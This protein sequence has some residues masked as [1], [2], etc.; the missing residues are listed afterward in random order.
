[1]KA[2]GH[3]GENSLSWRI[4]LPGLAPNSHLSP[5]A[6]L[7]HRYHRHR[8]RRGAW[9]RARDR[10]GRGPARK[11]TP[12]HRT[13]RKS[14]SVLLRL[15]AAASVVVPLGASAQQGPVLL[16]GIMELSGTGTTPGTNFDN[17]VKLAVK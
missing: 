3:S 12:I 16:F 7:A 5:L 6:D 9:L 10:G 2:A 13:G 11:L 1:M 8:R 17:G 15:L 4:S 14:M